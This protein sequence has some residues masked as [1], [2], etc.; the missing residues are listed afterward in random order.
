M[1]AGVGTVVVSAVGFSL[2]ASAAGER[3]KVLALTR[4]VSAGD[5]LEVRDL[6][7]AEAASETGVVPAADS[8]EVLGRRAR[9]PLVAGSLLAPG[10]FGGQR[11]YPREGQS[12]VAFAIEAGSASPHVTRGDRVAVLE[13]PDGAGTPASGEEE[14]AAPVVGTVA[15]AKAPESPGGARTVTVLMETGAVRRAA[16]IEHPRVVVLPAE[17]REAP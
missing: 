11:A 1:W 8:A 14:T 10:Q 17:G 2:V 13:G 5:V 4:D 6:R 15:E 9:V 16:G 3:E 12:E 7:Q